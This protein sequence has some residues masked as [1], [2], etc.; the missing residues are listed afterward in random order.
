MEA[1]WWRIPLGFL[2]VVGAPV[3]LWHV[4]RVVPAL[5][6]GEHE[7]SLPVGHV[8]MYDVFPRS[9]VTALLPLSAFAGF[10]LLLGVQFVVG[11]LTIAPAKGAFL[12]MGLTAPLTVLHWVVNAYNRPRALVPPAFRDQLGWVDVRRRRRSNRRAGRPDTDHLVEILDFGSPGTESVAICTE[13]GCRWRA[14]PDRRAHVPELSLR[15]KAT[16]HSS[17]IT[18]DTI[19]PTADV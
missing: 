19:R 6:R 17:R 10:V 7:G 16:R 15:N 9:Y 1:M 2:A 11:A 14:V 3:Y 13:A 4:W 8:R 18:V 12:L 5:W